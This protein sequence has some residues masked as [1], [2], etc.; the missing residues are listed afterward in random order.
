[1][2]GFAILVSLAGSAGRAD[3][4]PQKPAGSAADASLV[5]GSLRGDVQN[6]DAYDQASLSLAE[7]KRV[8]LPESATIRQTD[9]GDS[10]RIYMKKSLAFGGHP[11]APMSI[12]EARKNMG[13]A[14][15]REKGALKVATFGEWDS[16]K[17]GAA[18]IK[19]L[20]LVPKNIEILKH[21]GLSG[22][23]SSANKWTKS[24]RSTRYALINGHWWYGP[25]A[26]GEG[27]A[28]VATEPDRERRAE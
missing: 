27:W 17:E 24:N 22:D 6:G 14:T 19:L 28:V 16:R 13:C 2:R 7:I 20:I 9:E 5:L 4:P 10:L 1:M 15:Q 25:A 11:P 8:I 23:E 12:V 21:R 3:E 18:G 26:P